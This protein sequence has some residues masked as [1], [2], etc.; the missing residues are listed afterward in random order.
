MEATRS[1]F[2][3]F[4][5]PF[6]PE[7][8]LS[9]GHNKGV[10]YWALGV[11]IYECLVGVSPFYD[12]DQMRLFKKI[13]QGK[14]RYPSRSPVTRTADNLIR[15]LLQ[16][17]QSSRLGN[18]K[19]GHEDVKQHEWFRRIDLNKL[20]KRKIKAPWKPTIKDALDV[21]HFDDFSSAEKEVESSGPSLRQDEQSMF[22]DFGEIV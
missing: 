3:A 12:H 4:S 16:C 13:V 18:L 17:K 2:V 9:K 19:G 7:L 8:I 5:L 1:L 11:L 20:S 22:A 21:S 10:D 6:S 15:S 14:F